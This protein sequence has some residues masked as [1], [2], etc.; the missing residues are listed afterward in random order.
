MAKSIE[1]TSFTNLS[2]NKFTASG[3]VD[4]VSF[5]AATIVYRGEPIFKVQEENGEGEVGLQRMDA[6]TFN[7]GARI[8]IARTLKVER[9]RREN[10][11]AVELAKQSVK[12]LRRLCR[13]AGL[14]GYSKKGVRKDDLVEMLA[15]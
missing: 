11:D 8:A 1:I 2:D 7:R 3:T 9:L 10:T 12:E 15:A 5:S 13:E 4:G 6:S 14:K